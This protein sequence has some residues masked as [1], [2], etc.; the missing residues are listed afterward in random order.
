MKKVVELSLG[1]EFR[2]ETT[3]DSGLV[4][5]GIYSDT[6]NQYTEIPILK[7]HADAL[8]LALQEVCY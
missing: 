1:D 4:W 6:R 2:V 8:I 7:D 5:V 3:G